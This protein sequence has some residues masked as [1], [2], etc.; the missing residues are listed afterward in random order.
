MLCEASSLFTF[1]DTVLEKTLLRT[2]R[3]RHELRQ[4]GDTNERQS[5]I[6]SGARQDVEDAGAVALK[7]LRIEKTEFNAHLSVV[8]RVDETRT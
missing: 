7:Q 6:Q 8:L 1:R 3:L 4:F 5:E 2:E